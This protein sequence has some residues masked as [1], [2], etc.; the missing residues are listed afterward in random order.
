[1]GINIFRWG[2]TGQLDTIC[3]VK[4][5]VVIVIVVILVLVVIV[6]M[7]VVVLMVVI[8]TVILVMVILVVLVVRMPEYYVKCKINL[9]FGFNEHFC[10]LSVK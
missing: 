8:F 3:N 2:P 6:V 5:Q 9:V 4:T 10:N 1:M 7:M